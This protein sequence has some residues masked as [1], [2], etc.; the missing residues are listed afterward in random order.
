MIPKEKLPT[1]D[2][3]GKDYVQAKERVLEL[4]RQSDSFSLIT[5]IISDDD[6]RVVMQTTIK[7]DDR[8]F[9]GIASE[10]KNQEKPYENCETSSVARC[11]GFFG[12][13][14][15]EN[16]A[17]ADCTISYENTKTNIPV[18]SDRQVGLIKKLCEEV[19]A[20]EKEYI[21]EGMTIPEASNRITKLKEEQKS[22]QGSPKD[23]LSSEFLEDIG[24]PDKLKKDEDDL[25]G[26]KE[27]IYIRLYLKTQK[28]V[29][30]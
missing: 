13:G 18:A 30:Q 24:S 23:Y 12:V 1:I 7:I 15:I 8:V 28:Q 16:I 29:E 9:T 4:H 11:A 25:F 3:K 5:E 21:T 22:L 14:I 26:G 20:D 27:W 2:I 17:S 6:K 10:M 19:G